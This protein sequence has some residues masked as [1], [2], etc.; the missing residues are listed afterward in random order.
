MLLKGVFIFLLIIPSAINNGKELSSA[1]LGVWLFD[2]SS[3]ANNSMKLVKRDD[4]V[5]DRA[6]IVFQSNG[7]LL[8]RQNVG[9]CGTPPVQYG[10]YDGDWT[11]SADSVLT[12]HYE[13]WGGW[14]IEK[15]KIQELS[16]SA[17]V[18]SLLRWD[19]E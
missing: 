17:L 5:D 18:V 14:A 6:G 15:W 16:D 8:K 2:E 19:P 7:D 11:L 3:Y 10:N 1:I 13:Y 12:L 4:L 9:W